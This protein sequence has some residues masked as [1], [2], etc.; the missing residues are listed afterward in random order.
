MCLSGIGEAEDFTEKCIVSINNHIFKVN[1]GPFNICQIFGD[2][3]VLV[4]SSG[5]TILTD[6]CGITLESLQ[7]GA[8]YYLVCIFSYNLCFVNYFFP[9]K[10]CRVLSKI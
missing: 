10:T 8:S 4:D 7:H 6:E 5:Q 3:A 9:Y 1:V 2:E